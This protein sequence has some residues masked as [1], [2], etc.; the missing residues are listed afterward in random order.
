MMDPPTVVVDRPFFFFIYA[1]E[2]GTILFAG[3]VMNPA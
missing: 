3:R 2:S 1:P